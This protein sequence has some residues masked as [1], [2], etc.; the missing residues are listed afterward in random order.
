MTQDGQRAIS[1]SWDQT[2][3]VWD[4][5]SG[6]ELRT[7]SGRIRQVSSVAVTPDGQCVV[8]ASADNMV[9]VWQLETPEVLAT[10]TCESAARCCAFSDALNVIVA[11]E[12]GGHLHFLRL[13]E[14]K[15]K[16]ET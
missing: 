3:E 4:L 6:R 10:F 1:A 9:K 12:V 13:E 15:P 2:V 8:S 5:A 11:G 14:P 7:L 16:T